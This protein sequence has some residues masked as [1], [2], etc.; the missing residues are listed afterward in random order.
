MLKFYFSGHNYEYEA[1]N[2]L[3]I[4]DSNIDYEISDID[5]FDG[6]GL[7][8]V[9]HLHE[10]ELIYAKALLYKDNQLLFEFSLNSNDIIL[11]KSGTKKL[12]KILV[13]KTIHNVLKSYYNVYPDYGILTGVRVVKILITANRNLKSDEEI[14][15]ILRNTY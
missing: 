6:T 7:S 15:Y 2:A 8:L 14:N 1:R 5:S 3:R 13:M 9:S 11:E 4:F 12:K 10:S